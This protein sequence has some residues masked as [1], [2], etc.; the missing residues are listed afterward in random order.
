MAKRSSN[1]KLLIKQI[2]GFVIYSIICIFAIYLIV[3]LMNGNKKSLFGYTIRI[4]VSGSMEP[5][6]QTNSIN[7]IKL[8]DIEDIKVNDVVCFNYS[9]DVI[10]R[11]IEIKTNEDGDIVLHTKGDANEKPD[12]VEVYDEMVIGKVV[13]TFNGASGLISKYSISP[14]N[15]DSVA[16]SRDLISK[17]IIIG[18]IIFIVIYIIEVIKI[19][20]IS[21]GK[22]DRYNKVID[23]YI[24]DIDELIMYKEL[25][26]DL[27]DYEVENSSETRFR[28]LLNGFSKAKAGIE[29]DKL[30]SAIKHYKKHIKHCLWLSKLGDKIDSTDKHYKK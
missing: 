8:C 29:I 14:G 23:E 12:D 27:K 20:V 4:V 17:L 6:I 13:K 18:I 30:H 16:L 15:I 1:E 9:Q 19:L 11:V 26:K 7:I 28:F 25:L 21:F 10:H 2:I 3:G 22:N 24:N 5:E